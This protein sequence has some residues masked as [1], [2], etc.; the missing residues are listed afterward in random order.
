MLFGNPACRSASSCGWVRLSIP[1]LSGAV[2]LFL[3]VFAP[4]FPKLATL[5]LEGCFRERQ[6]SRNGQGVLHFLCKPVS[7]SGFQWVG[8]AFASLHHL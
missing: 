5:P 3:S 7:P 2:C 8:F 4:E 6:S 1:V